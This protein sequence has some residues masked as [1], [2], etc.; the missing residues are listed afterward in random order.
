MP[1]EGTN[2]LTRRDTLSGSGGN[3]LGSSTGRFNGP[4]SGG[5][6]T[7]DDNASSQF[8]PSCE[9][10]SQRQDQHLLG[11]S[12]HHLHRNQEPDAVSQVTGCGV[13]QMGAVSV[14]AIPLGLKRRVGLFSGIALIVGTMIG[15]GIFLS[16]RNVLKRSGS[17]GMSLIVWSLSGLLSLLG[18][19]CYAELGTLI[20]KSGAEYSYILEAFGG[21]FAFLFSWISVFILKPAMLSI[22]CLTLSE[23]IVSPLFPLC[24]QSGLLIKLFTIFS[25]GEYKISSKTKHFQQLS[26]KEFKYVTRISYL[27][28]INHKFCLIQLTLI[29][30]PSTYS[31]NHIFE[32]L[33][34]QPGYRNSESVYGSQIGGHFHSCCRW[35]DSNR[36]R[37]SRFRLQ[38]FRGVENLFFGYSDSLLQ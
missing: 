35:L 26:T 31:N 16:P 29:S 1:T 25:I 22:I 18:A 37:S 12:H 5:G 38:R 15:S 6:L 28:S 20:S 3:F 11:A 13:S 9:N 8:A 23:Y 10:L 27:L 14:P 4:D 32:L 19:L 30:S 24:P 36:S 2:K 33:Q 21:P 17:V 34:C 7:D